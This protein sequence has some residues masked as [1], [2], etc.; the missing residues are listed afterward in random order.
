MNLSLVVYQAYFF[1]Q[2]IMNIVENKSLRS[3]RYDKSRD[4]TVFTY[5]DWWR[6]KG[7]WAR[8]FHQKR[9][10]VIYDSHVNDI[11]S[12]TYVYYWNL[13]MSFVIF[14]YTFTIHPSKSLE[15]T[16]LTAGSAFMNYITGMSFNS[17]QND[18]II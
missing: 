3:K 12:I 6:L 2:L 4:N 10:Y 7:T 1:I 17:V 18:P 5:I 8:N 13:V 16:N 11:K 15:K 14:I 9:K